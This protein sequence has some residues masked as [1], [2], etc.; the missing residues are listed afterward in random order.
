MYIYIYIYIYIYTHI[1]I[2]IYTHMCV[3]I[4]IYIY[5]HRY[6]HLLRAH[7]CWPNLRST[8]S[9]AEDIISCHI[10]NVY[11]VIRYDSISHV[12]IGYVIILC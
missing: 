1:Y 8:C 5:I 9:S 3:Y 11:N 2:Y 4:Y 10:I 12:I 6:L 7:I